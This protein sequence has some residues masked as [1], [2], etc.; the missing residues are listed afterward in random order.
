[1]ISNNF[2]VLNKQK[3]KLVRINLNQYKRELWNFCPRA[4]ASRNEVHLLTLSTQ[5]F[6]Q[7]HIETLPQ[8]LYK[9]A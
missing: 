5:Y 4:R 2:F 7:V 8:K 9:Y 6:I 1:M 3:T